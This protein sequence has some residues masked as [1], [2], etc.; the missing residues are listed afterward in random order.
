MIAI[1]YFKSVYYY[2][3]PIRDQLFHL[4][5]I[6]GNSSSNTSSVSKNNNDILSIGDMF[7]S[8]SHIKGIIGKYHTNLSGDKNWRIHQSGIS[9]NSLSGRFEVICSLQYTENQRIRKMNYENRNTDDY[10]KMIPQIKCRGKH[11]SYK[12]KWSEG[13][14]ICKVINNHTCLESQENSN[15]SRKVKFHTSSLANMATSYANTSTYHNA[16]QESIACYLSDNLKIS[17]ESFPYQSMYRTIGHIKYR[18]FGTP[19]EQYA[20][21]IPFLETIRMIDSDT[22]IFLKVFANN[23]SSTSSTT[24][25]FQ[26]ESLSNTSKSISFSL[27]FGAISIIPG[28]SVRRMKFYEKNPSYELNTKQYDATFC[29]DVFRGCSHDVIYPLQDKE[30]IVDSFTKDA[31]NESH[32]TWSFHLETT[33]H[34]LGIRQKHH[35]DI[36]DRFRGNDKIHTKFMGESTIF[37]CIFHL[38]EDLKCSTLGSATKEDIHNFDLLAHEKD[39]ILHNKHINSFNLSAKQK[40][41]HYLQHR[42]LT[43]NSSPSRFCNSHIKAD[44]EGYKSIQLCESWHSDMEKKISRRIVFK[45]L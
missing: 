24:S 37:D 8:I 45:S 25:Y 14:Y 43:T 6:M 28:S 41:Q 33:N 9:K 13:F 44:H 22:R 32:N 39:I 26:K 12:N 19:Q 7:S 3:H 40:T 18:T 10:V 15:S 34:V 38:K 20:K 31:E 27:R 36:F 11:F 16:S 29:N 42:V 30:H 17:K 35:V 1:L 2:Y 23:D 5:S 4:S 21:I